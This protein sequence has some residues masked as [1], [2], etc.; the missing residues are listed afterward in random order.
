MEPGWW[1]YFRDTDDPYPVAYF[2]SDVPAPEPVPTE[3][4]IVPTVTASRPP[5]RW[6]NLAGDEGNG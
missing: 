4:H 1:L 3:T 2:V 5:S 6:Y